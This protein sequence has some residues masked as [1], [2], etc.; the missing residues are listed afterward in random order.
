MPKKRKTLPK[1]FDEIVKRGNVEEIIKVF[2]KC[3]INAYGGYGNKTALM[4]PDL[5]VEVIRYLVENGADINLPSKYGDTPLSEH[6]FFKPENVPLLIEL[7][8]DIN[9]H[10]EMGNTALQRAALRFRPLSVKILLESGADINERSGNSKKTPL[11]DCLTVCRP[12]DI[13]NAVKVADLLIKAGAEITDD[14]RKSV[15]KIGENFEFYRD[16]FNP[17]YLEETDNALTELYGMFDVEPVPKKK[18]Y[19][20]VSTITVKSKKWQKQ[21]DELWN[22]LVPGSGHASTVQGEVIRIVGKVSYEIL[23]NGAMNW[24]REYKQLPQALPEYFGMGSNID[25]E[26]VRLA[27]NISA[28]SSEDELN[29]LTELAVKWVLANPEP[30][31]LDKVDYRR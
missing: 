31:K 1:D 27:K 2:D 20:G 21:F 29:R 3:E 23:D 25:E 12:A 28:N 10:T 18:V 4:N 7:G 6:A 26:A 14:M 9:F 17:E 11:E 30:I 15:T 5:P 19:D 22:L 16:S 24:S 13:V 8:A